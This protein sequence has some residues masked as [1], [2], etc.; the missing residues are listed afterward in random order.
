M[1]SQLV[2][3]LTN[4]LSEIPR[5]LDAIGAFFD[6]IPDAGPARFD[7]SLAVEE[8]LS[9]V[10]RYAYPEGERHMISV[11]LSVQDGVVH[12]HLVDTG[13]PFDP[14]SVP[15]PDIDADLD[16]RQVGGLGVHF[17][18]R[19]MQDVRYDRVDGRNEVRLMR[20]LAVPP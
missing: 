13:R 19:M 6:D 17:V 15:E 2:I 8:L 20:S 12:C 10:I 7:V 5:V 3:H 1:P 16:D 9:N 11:T 14:L 18:R 4:S